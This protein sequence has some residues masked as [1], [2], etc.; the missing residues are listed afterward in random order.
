MKKL[1][2]NIGILLAAIVLATGCKESGTASLSEQ[3]ELGQRYL[4]ELDYE[5]AIV[6]FQ[7]A[8]EIDP[9]AMDAYVGLAEAHMALGNMEE[10]LAAAEQGIA[11]FEGLEDADKTEERTALYENLLEIA[12]RLREELEAKAESAVEESQAIQ[13]DSENADE[14][15]TTAETTEASMAET[16]T[17]GAETMTAPE[18]EAVLETTAVPETTVPETLPP[19]VPETTAPVPAE[20]VPVETSAPSETAPTETEMVQ[21]GLYIN[22]SAANGSTLAD[23]VV[24]MTD[25]MT[26]SDLEAQIP[27]LQ[28]FYWSA[29]DEYIGFIKD[30]TLLFR[31]YINYDP[32]GGF[33]SAFSNL[34][35]SE[36]DAAVID[37]NNAVYTENPNAEDS[38]YQAAFRTRFANEPLNK[39]TYV[40]MILATPVPE[41]LF[42]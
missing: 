14:V 18:T 40:E 37:F 7:K 34:S 11:V 32:S 39:N 41:E 6:A 10:A 35:S 29:A 31:I 30:N 33:S 42:P 36:A 2:K 23:V 21:S 12:E 8:I 25:N 4:E 3:L 13:D 17:A 16:E 20:T 19:T 26:L 15:E 24:G 9:K 1:L 38:A 27:G 22:E 5:S 28:Y